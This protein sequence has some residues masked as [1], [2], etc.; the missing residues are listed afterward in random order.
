MYGRRPVPRECSRANHGG[1]GDVVAHPD[2]VAGLRTATAR[3]LVGRSGTI[4][5][6]L[7]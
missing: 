6:F 2:L 4:G 1:L 7:A 3:F 5:T